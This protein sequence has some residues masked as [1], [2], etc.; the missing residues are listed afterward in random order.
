M[1]FLRKTDYTKIDS[2]EFYPTQKILGLT[3]IKPKS[4]CKE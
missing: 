3:L 1:Q 4:S 2:T